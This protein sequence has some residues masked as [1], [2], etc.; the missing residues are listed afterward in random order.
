MVSFAF[1]I[2]VVPLHAWLTSAH[3][4]APT[5]GSMILAGLLLKLG[6]YGFIRFVHGLFPEVVAQNRELLCAVVVVATIYA[7]FAAYRQT[8]LKRLLAFSSIIHMNFSIW[9]LCSGT[10]EGLAAVVHTSIHHGLVATALFFIVGSLYE[11][12]GVRNIQYYS[13]IASVFPETT[14]WFWFFMFANAGLP[15]LSGFPGELASVT[16]ILADNHLPGLLT[17]I[18]LF[19]NTAFIFVMTSRVTLGAP[20]RYVD[21]KTG[22]YIEYPP[23]MTRSEDLVMRYLAV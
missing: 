23:D 21:S 11:R 9:A 19:G 8:D 5:A 7:L 20:L 18:P 17:L 14:K 15:F 4:E 13:G 2:P 16:A 1:K 3:V 10:T 6:S 22:E 12:R